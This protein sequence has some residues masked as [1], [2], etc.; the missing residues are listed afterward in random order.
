MTQIDCV[1]Q[2]SPEDVRRLIDQFAVRSSSDF[3]LMSTGLGGG[4]HWRP[5]R[6]VHQGDKVLLRRSDQQRVLPWGSTHLAVVISPMDKGSRIV[7][8]SVAEMKWA[9]LCGLAALALFFGMVA[10]LGKAPLAALFVVATLVAAWALPRRI[11]AEQ[12]KDLQAIT[13]V[14][15]GLAPQS[16]K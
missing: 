9:A 12:E 14:L 8:K 13:R 15:N 3:W 7:V 2:R 4:P 6:A 1:S 11:K 10:V 5:F 16:G